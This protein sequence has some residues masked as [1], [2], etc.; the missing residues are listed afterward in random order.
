MEINV[1]VSDLKS[2]IINDCD[3]HELSED[4]ILDD[5]IL[6][7]NEGR[8]NLDSLDI[9]Q[10]SVAIKNKYGVRIE[11]NAESRNAFVNLKNLATYI[12]DQL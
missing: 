8:V 12:Q 6:V 4:M 7:G 5:E 1:I 3:K 9:L 11:R 10:L 2:M